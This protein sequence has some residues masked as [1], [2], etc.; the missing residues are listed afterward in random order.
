VALTIVT[1]RQAPLSLQQHLE[2]TPDILNCSA[3]EL[4][5]ELQPLMM[6]QAVPNPPPNDKK[7]VK[8][9]EL[10]NND[11]FDR[12]T[13]FCTAAFIFVCP[14]SES[15]ARPVQRAFSAHPRF[16]AN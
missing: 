2:I 14:Y 6:A 7:R 4:E 5:G 3:E 12:G 13:G 9:Y 15:L 10:R 11:W 16:A 8:V 1:Q